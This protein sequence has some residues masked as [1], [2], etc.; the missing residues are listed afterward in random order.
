MD[1]KDIFIIPTNDKPVKIIIENDGELSETIK[2]LPTVREL[3]QEVKLSLY[4]LLKRKGISTQQYRVEKG[5]LRKGYLGEV[6]NFIKKRDETTYNLIRRFMKTEQTSLIYT[7]KMGFSMEVNAK[8][9]IIGD[10]HV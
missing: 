3:K 2:S 5:K 10:A 1:D 6:L 9:G 7:R 8:F 4:L